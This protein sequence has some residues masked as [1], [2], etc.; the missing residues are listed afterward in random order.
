MKIKKVRS[1]MELLNKA[2]T[3]P[4]YA[5]LIVSAARNL[6]GSVKNGD[7]QGAFRVLERNMIDCGGGE[8]SIVAEV[9]FC[10]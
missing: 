8:D 4:A 5:K 3:E 10:I 7:I 2:H 6:G 9:N 1:L